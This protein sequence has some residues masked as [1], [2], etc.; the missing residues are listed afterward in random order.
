MRVSRI[1]IRKI[2]NSLDQNSSWEADSCPAC[3][4]I[5]NLLRMPKVYFRVHKSPWFD[6]ILSQL[7]PVHTLTF[8]FFDI[9]FNVILPPTPRSPKRHLPFRLFDQNFVRFPMH[10]TCSVHVLLSFIVLQISM[11]NVGLQIMNL[12]IVTAL[13]LAS[14]SGLGPTNP[15]IQWVPGVLSPKGKAAWTWSWPLACI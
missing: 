8:C 10:A 6:P 7:N 3:N 13:L 14:P 15:P 4:E 1:F 9:C 12:L 5:P 2:T 11:E